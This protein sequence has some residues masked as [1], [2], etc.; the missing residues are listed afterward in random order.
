MDAN[1]GTSVDVAAIIVSG[2]Q[3]VQVGSQPSPRVL[4]CG[5]LLVKISEGR[6]F[7]SRGE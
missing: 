3:A 1:V 4:V 7:K 6:L 5:A 2:C